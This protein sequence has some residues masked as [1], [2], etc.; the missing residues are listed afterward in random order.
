MHVTE[1]IVARQTILSNLANHDWDLL[2]K[3]VQ[4]SFTAMKKCPVKPLTGHCSRIPI[5]FLWTL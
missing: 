1:E 3:Q 4:G 5:G 2:A